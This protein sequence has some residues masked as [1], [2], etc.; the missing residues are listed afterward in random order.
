MSH[1]LPDDP[2]S[3]TQR[4]LSSYSVKEIIVNSIMALVGQEVDSQDASQ[5]M[6]TGGGSEQIYS[7]DEDEE[8]YVKLFPGTT[9]VYEKCEN[10]DRYW[11]AEKESSIDETLM[12]FQKFIDSEEFKRDF[13]GV[14]K[15]LRYL[16]LKDHPQLFHTESSTEASEDLWEE[17]DLDTERDNHTSMYEDEK[18]SDNESPNQAVTG[19]DKEQ[20]QLLN[21]STSETTRNRFVQSGPK[22]HTTITPANFISHPTASSDDPHSLEMANGYT[23]SQRFSRDARKINALVLLLDSYTKFAQQQQTIATTIHTENNTGS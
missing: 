17:D 12:T 13:D 15:T 19:N 22:S 14:L 6:V 3:V 11:V 21:A 7:S 8:S 10:G 9:N 5:T 1:T 23:M 20:I 16:K 4:P 2:T 18:Y